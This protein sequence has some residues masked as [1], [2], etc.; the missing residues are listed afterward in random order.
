MNLLLAALV[1]AWGSVPPAVRHSHVGGDD[2]R[3]C[4]RHHGRDA[5]RH[6]HGNDA[7]GHFHERSDRSSQDVSTRILAGVI[8][9]L[10]WGWLGLHVSLPVTEDE[11]SDGGPDGAVPTVFRLVDMLPT[12]TV[13]TCGFA[14]HSLS[15]E[16][17]SGF[18]GFVA[19]AP[20]QRS[21]D[22]LPAAPLCDR[23][24]RERSGVLLV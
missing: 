10:H 14:G 4:H 16:P 17:P 18:V 15:P 20:L 3:H 12:P 21:P 8:V 22:L 2:A 9:H 5:H 24:R 11:R 19:A 6:F 7:H 13:G 23:A 1:V